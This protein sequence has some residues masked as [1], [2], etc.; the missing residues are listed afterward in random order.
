KGQANGSSSKA[1]LLAVVDTSNGGP[2]R[3]RGEVKT[4]ANKKTKEQVGLANL[5]LHHLLCRKYH[6][7]SVLVSRRKENSFCAVKAAN[8]LFIVIATE[9]HQQLVNE[10]GAAIHV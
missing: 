8:L 3:K 5:V 7:R 9:S 2:K 1:A 6:V 4:A 10:V